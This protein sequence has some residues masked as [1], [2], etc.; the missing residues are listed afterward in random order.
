MHSHLKVTVT[1][2]ISSNAH[3]SFSPAGEIDAVMLR[4]TLGM[5]TQILRKIEKIGNLLLYHGLE[6]AF[7]FLRK[8]AGLGASSEAGSGTFNRSSR[9]CD[10]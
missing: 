5:S 6:V 1:L 9:R 10:N 8:L 3:K 4:L 2:K 7:F